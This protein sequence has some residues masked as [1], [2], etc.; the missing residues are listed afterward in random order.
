MTSLGA[1]FLLQNDSSGLV[2]AAFG[3]FM[4][5]VWLVIGV[6][7]IVGGWKVFEKAGQP[8]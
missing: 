5:L 6:V 7:A 2:G 3:G 4:T 8:G 1:L